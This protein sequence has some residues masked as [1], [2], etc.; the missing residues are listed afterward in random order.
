MSW[1]ETGPRASEPQ[2]AETANEGISIGLDGNGNVLR[3]ALTSPVFAA[4]PTTRVASVEPQ[5]AVRAIEPG[6]FSLALLAGAGVAL[7]GGLVWAGVVIATK[8]DIGIL[9]WLVGGAT[10]LVIVRVTGGP[11][12]TAGRAMA[13]LL[14]AAGILVGK[15]VIFVHAVKH[16]LGAQL[17]AQGLSVGYLDTRQMSIF[18][19]NFGNIVRPVYILWIALAFFAAFRTADGKPVFK[20]RR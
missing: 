7:I 5:N 18:V 8:F 16:V 3:T 9:A 11:I 13:G 1:P 14:A 2:V 19:H 12:G 17:A 4:E 6:P 20:R 15:Y 10:G